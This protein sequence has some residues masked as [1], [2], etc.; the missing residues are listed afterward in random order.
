[1]CLHIVNRWKVI[2]DKTCFG[3]K[4]L[5]IKLLSQKGLTKFLLL[6]TEKQY[7]HGHSHLN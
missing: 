5:S 2:P 7:H 1:M 6:Y 4:T 3:E